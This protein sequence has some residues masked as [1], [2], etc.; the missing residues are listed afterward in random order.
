[1][2]TRNAQP[3]TRNPKLVTRN[4]N[5]KRPAQ[6]GWRFQNTVDKRANRLSRQPANGRTGKIDKW[7]RKVRNALRFAPCALRN[8]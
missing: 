7:N 1:M 3:G 5:A 6:S 4:F 8:P 2:K